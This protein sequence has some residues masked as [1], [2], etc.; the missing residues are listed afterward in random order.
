MCWHCVGCPVFPILV[1]VFLQ[2]M[3]LEDE[4]PLI[5]TLPPFQEV[6]STKWVDVLSLPWR[7]IEALP[8]LRWFTFYH[9]SNSR[10]VRTGDTRPDTTTTFMEIPCLVFSFNIALFY[11]ILIFRWVE[12]VFDSLVWDT[13]A[14]RIF[15]FLDP[16]SFTS[17]AYWFRNISVSLF[18][19]QVN[20]P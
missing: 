12:I 18:E 15:L 16:T 10:T 4:M 17:D 3:A 19:E 5:L 11:F 2:K 8:M 14:I 1:V 20:F 6:L 7:S 9:E 13:C